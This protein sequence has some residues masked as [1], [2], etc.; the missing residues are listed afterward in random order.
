ISAIFKVLMLPV[1]PASGFHNSLDTTIIRSKLPCRTGNA[2]K[3][4][5]SLLPAFGP[6]I[7]RILYN[8]R[9]I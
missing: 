6:P 8:H 4:G 3:P 9:Q 7:L 2:K 5:E 1:H